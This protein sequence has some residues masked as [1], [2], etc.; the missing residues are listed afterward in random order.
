MIREILFIIAWLVATICL[1][2][3]IICSFITI[4]GEHS[5]FGMAIC[6]A[7]KYWYFVFPFWGSMGWVRI[8]N[9]IG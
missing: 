1:V 7:L 5:Y 6:F 3:I 2:A 9:W 8:D 4:P